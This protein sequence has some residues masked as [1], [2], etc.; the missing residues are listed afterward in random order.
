MG[1][2]SEMP[3]NFH[4]KKN[5]PQSNADVDCSTHP[6]RPL[7]LHPQASVKA[8][9]TRRKQGATCLDCKG[10]DGETFKFIKKKIHSIFLQTT[11]RVSVYLPN[12]PFPA[13]YSCSSFT[14]KFGD[15]YKENTISGN[16]GGYLDSMY[17]FLLFVLLERQS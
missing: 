12:F 6:I 2:I 7:I 4:R 5:S 17:M 15:E 1:Y 14:F 11:G 16:F 8:Q 9:E 13:S 10:T 3:R